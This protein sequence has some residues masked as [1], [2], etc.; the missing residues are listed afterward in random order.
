LEKDFTKLKEYLD[1]HYEESVFDDL[2]K[3]GTDATVFLHDHLIRSGRVKENKKYD[4]NFIP[5]DGKKEE[6]IQ[7]VIVKCLCFSE[8]NESVGPLIKMNNEAMIKRLEPIFAPG[9]RHHI[10][11]KTLFP[12]MEQRQVL[13]FTLL[14]G[15]VLRGI[16]SGFSRYEITLSMKG[17][18]PLTILRHAVYDLRDKNGRCYLKKAVESR[19]GRL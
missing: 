3:T 16:I 10:K 7:K 19:D 15:E 6:E 18:L 17:E 12:L 4:I 8:I 9:P 2:Q 13:L 1:D 11:N 14:E 5:N